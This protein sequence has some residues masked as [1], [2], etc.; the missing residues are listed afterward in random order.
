MSLHCVCVCVRDNDCAN[1][2]FL[3]HCNYKLL[4]L[5]KEVFP[6]FVLYKIYI[7]LL[8]IQYLFFLH[9]L[10]FLKLVDNFVI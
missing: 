1:V 4:Y 8:W 3:C 7:K 10:G 9:L 2:H 6:K 5:K